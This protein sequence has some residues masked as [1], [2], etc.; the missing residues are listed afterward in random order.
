ST[1]Q[2]ITTNVTNLNRDLTNKINSNLDVAKSFAT[3]IAVA[4]AN[5]AREQAIASADGK[6]TEE[7]RK[8]I[9]QAQEN[10]N[11]AI[12]RADKAKQDAINVASTDATNKANNALNSA[13]AFV[14]AEITTVNNKVHN[15]ESNLNILSNEIKSKVSQS[16]MEKSISNITIG[17]RNLALG[18][19]LNYSNP[20]SRFDGE[21]NKCPSV[22]KVITDGLKVGDIVT[23]RLLYK[24]E[25]II[26]ASGKTNSAWLQGAGDV[27]GWGSGAFSGSVR[28][29]N[30]S[31]NGTY[32][33][34]YSF[35]VT[36]EHMKN[37]YWDVNLRH[38]YILSG[39]VC[40]KMFKVEK[41][42]KATDW[43]PAPEDTNSLIVDSIKVINSKISDVSSSVTQLRDSVTT[44]IRAI[45]S[46]TQS[47]ETTLNGKASKQEVTEVNNRV[48]T[49]KASLDGITQRVSATESKTQTL[50]S[51]LNGKA[52][53]QE[54]NNVSSKVASIETSLNG[55]TQRVSSAE[56]NINKT[57]DR[58][59]SLASKEEVAQLKITTNSISTEVSKK[60]NSNELISKI[61]QSAETVQINASKINLQGYVTVGELGSSNVT[62]INNAHITSGTIEGRTMIALNG[63][64]K[65]NGVLTVNN[66]ESYLEYFRCREAWMMS[67]YANGW[68]VPLIHS[69]FGVKDSETASDMIDEISFYRG[70]DGRN[71]LQITNTKTGRVEYIELYRSAFDTVTILNRLDRI[72]A[73]LAGL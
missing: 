2:T 51:N 14:N 70:T 61:N 7:E 42:N 53:K 34:L 29:N 63:T 28:L 62:T 72:D 20:Y 47:I 35:T 69:K 56:S 41:G 60:V 18:T 43:T 6:I 12:A 64:G 48:A 15:V 8:R 73:K 24:Y 55:I 13:K 16:D 32:E 59:N 44:D 19:S 26:Q 3:D 40:W 50:E 57:N 23:V 38:D 9:Q 11:V 33:F 25:N 46:K 1:T 27:T 71:Y 30:F 39:S 22:A 67:P 54:V 10:L 66:G 68:R 31:G 36:K 58:I 21:V 4:K 17:G 45:N 52:S 65:Q 5:L 49:I 37:N